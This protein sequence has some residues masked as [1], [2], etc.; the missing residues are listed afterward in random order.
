MAVA[1]CATESPVVTLSRMLIADQ[2]RTL[3]CQ[4]YAASLDP[5][6]SLGKRERLAAAADWNEQMATAMDALGV[7]SAGGTDLFALGAAAG[8]AL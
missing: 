6:A 5:W 1:A 7:S 3:A 8:V 4:C 2:C